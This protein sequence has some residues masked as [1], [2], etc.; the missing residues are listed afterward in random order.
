MNRSRWLSF[1]LAFTMLLTLV[2]PVGGIADEADVPAVSEA[3]D[4]AAEEAAQAA[5][6]AA[7]AEQ[8]AAEA[9]AQAAAEEAARIAAEEAAAQAAAEEAARIAAEEAA[10]QAAAE[11]AARIAAEEAAAQAAAEEAARIAAEEA[12]AQA[13]AEEAARIAAEEAAAQAAA[14]AAAAE[15]A[16]EEAPQASEPVE[17]APV[18]E[19]PVAEVP[20]EEAP[21]EEAPVEETPVEEVPAEETP[22][23][24]APAE[25]APVEEA[26]VEEVPAE[27]PETIEADTPAEAPAP[28]EAPISFDETEDTTT[29]EPSDG[30]TDQIIITQQPT[31]Q[32]SE[33]GKTVTFTV[34]AENV[35]D[36]QWQYTTNL[37]T[38]NNCTSGGGFDTSLPNTLRFTMTSAM[39]GYYFR[40]KLSNYVDSR[41][42]SSVHVELVQTITITTQPKD[43]EAYKGET[44]TFK[45]VASGATHYQW[46][47]SINKTVW[48]DIEDTSTEYY[49][50]T[51]ATLSFKMDA[52]YSNMYY[53]CVLSNPGAS[54][55]S[56]PAQAKLKILTVPEIT[57]VTP[58]NGN[59]M[60]I[61]WKGVEKATGYILYYNT[62]ANMA[63]A[64]T[65]ELGNVA[66]YRLTG[67]E[68]NKLY[69]FWVSAETNYG[70]T[71][72]S[73][74]KTGKT[75]D[76]AE[77]TVKADKESAAQSQLVTFTSK[78]T[79]TYTDLWY[80][81][82]YSPDGVTW[83]SCTSSFTGYNTPTMKLNATEALLDNYYRLKIAEKFAPNR[84]WF[85]A[86]VKVT[87]IPGANVQVPKVTT[88]KSLLAAPG[89][90]LNYDFMTEGNLTLSW[91]ANESNGVYTVKILLMNAMPSNSVA[92]SVVDVLYSKTGT[93]TSYTI[94]KS[95]MARASYVKIWIRAQDQDYELNNL[96]SSMWFGLKLTASESVTI[97]SVTCS[98]SVAV[99]ANSISDYNWAKKGDLT[100][101]W[102]AKNG[103]GKY[104]VKAILTNQVP[105]FSGANTPVANGVVKAVTNDTVNTLHVSTYQMKQ[106][107]YLKVFI[108]AQDANYALNGKTY[109]Y[110]F[111]L[112]LKPDRKVTDLTIT[113]S[114]I[115]I[116]INK[117][118][119]FN[120][121]KYGDLI[122]N[123]KATNGNGKFV[124]KA[125]LTSVSPTFG[126]ATPGVVKTVINNKTYTSSIKITKKE[127]TTLMSQGKYIKFVVTAQDVNYDRNGASVS[128]E[129]GIFLAP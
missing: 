65:E 114:K 68:Y 40:C 8:A 44:V 75:G 104:N 29:V 113:N 129:F 51:T 118:V 52:K 23:D 85:S 86:P 116:D 56:D 112:L 105:N 30:S 110:Q 81:W 60:T 58:S 38:W 5:A 49:G 36:Y 16:V 28:A 98:P 76:E 103:N 32:V 2:C 79:D 123:L 19:A 96:T 4:T 15:Q 64:K 62:T 73:A 21:V 115:N 26:P 3:V 119:A 39:A 59:C 87:F 6:E 37:S 120:I 50:G 90:V 126:A 14:E 72:A 9:A 77:V 128:K 66:S 69:Y 57:S 93:A 111:A 95:D 42:T 97:S 94:K 1:I 82:Q 71:G 22:A 33:L 10:A 18:E 99:S 31:D 24:E 47:Y 43:Q 101:K 67:L 7:A 13:A 102:T 41:N 91:H 61:K 122:I 121:N 25:E 34:V 88:D 84:E 48:T 45:V 74:S 124:V 27:E 127:L 100:I 80:K 78:I 54:K 109:S 46:Q 70:P 35:T 106:A 107:K 125:V 89:S 92:T 12:A 53:R 17:E 55:P 108:Q 11:E 117:S 83:T 20:A 63:T